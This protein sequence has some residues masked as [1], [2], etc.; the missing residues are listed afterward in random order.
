MFALL[1]G[2]WPFAQANAK[3]NFFTAMQ[4]NLQADPSMSPTRIL[5]AM[6]GKNLTDGAIQLLEGLLTVNPQNLTDPAQR[7]SMRE[8]ADTDWMAAAAPVAAH[9]GGGAGRS[10]ASA[11]PA[12]PPPAAP[13]PA[14]PAVAPHFPQ[15]RSCGAVP[16]A[17]PAQ[18]HALSVGS[19]D[20]GGTFLLPVV[21]RQKAC[22]G[23]V[24]SLW[25]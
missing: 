10:L 24:H 13:A 4:D 3:C 22:Y 9:T 1:L 7:L 2:G 25:V 12:A 5:L 17:A 21:G 19:D 11:V 14:V 8:V 18:Y 20:A 15:W 23:D 6:Y 16:D